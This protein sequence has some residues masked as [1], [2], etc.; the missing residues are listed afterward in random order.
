[1][2]DPVHLALIRLV[3]ISQK[4]ENSVQ[5]EDANFVFERAAIFL[6]VAAGDGGSNGDVAE[7]FVFVNAF[8]GLRGK[9]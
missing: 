4:V 9:R 3:I 7:E 2:F 6:G 8:A 5:D 1:M